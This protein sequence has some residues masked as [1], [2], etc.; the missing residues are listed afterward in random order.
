MFAESATL[1]ACTLHL[2]PVVEM[3]VLCSTADSVQ[4]SLSK[5]CVLHLIVVD[6]LSIVCLTR[7]QVLPAATQDSHHDACLLMLRPTVSYCAG[8][9]ALQLNIRRASRQLAGLCSSRLTGSSI[10]SSRQHSTVVRSTDM[11]VDVTRENFQ[12]VLP[13]IRDAL[14]RCTCN[15]ASSS[16]MLHSLVCAV[17]MLSAVRACYLAGTFYS[18]DCEMTGLFTGE[19]PTQAA[20]S[21]H[22]TAA[23]MFS[24]NV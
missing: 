23:H 22:A 24:G 15:S 4:A 13:A 16:K 5:Q 14:E 1:R 10:S 6:V 7:N 20:V 3:T 2:H 19:L 18:F 9:C 8:F 12:K 11:A 17:C 21:L